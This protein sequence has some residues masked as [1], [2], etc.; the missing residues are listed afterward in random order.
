[1]LMAQSHA[2][3]GWLS[4]TANTN[5][6]APRSRSVPGGNDRIQF[7]AA[8]GSLLAQDEV[9]PATAP[10][11]LSPALSELAQPSASSGLCWAH[12]CAIDSTPLAR[13]ASGSNDR[14]AT[15]RYGSSR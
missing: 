10:L 3:R 4:A 12:A 9:I 7:P 13:D 2:S 6:A 5:E 14:R 8:Y 11:R 15:H 1:M